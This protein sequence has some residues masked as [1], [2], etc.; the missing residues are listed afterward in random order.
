MKTLLL[1]LAISLAGCAAHPVSD[2][3]LDALSI[4]DRRNREALAEDLQIEASIKDVL[5]DE[6]ELMLRSHIAT[7]TFNGKLLVTGEVP[8]AASQKALIERLRIIK[9]VKEVHD[10]LSIGAAIGLD[11]Q[12]QDQAL[13]S[14]LLGAIDQIRSFDGFGVTNVNLI[15]EN[16]TVYLMGLMHRKEGATVVNVVRH[17]NGVQRIIAIFEYLD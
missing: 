2:Q 4:N 8:D 12:Q 15:V 1:S 14:Q 3:E 10:N 13:K 11:R 5:A 6:T 16:G 9:H 7:A 17:Q